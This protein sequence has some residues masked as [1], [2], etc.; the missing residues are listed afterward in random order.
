MLIENQTLLNLYVQ[1]P[2]VK[3]VHIGVGKIDA[4][5]LR[6][7]YK[8]KKILTNNDT[9]FMEA[10]KLNF[11]SI[12]N[13]RFDIKK[14]VCKVM[15]GN[16]I[17]GNI[18]CTELSKGNLDWSEICVLALQTHYIYTI[19][20]IITPANESLIVQNA[21]VLDGHGTKISIIE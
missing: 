5:H 12:I 14:Q 4:K 16:N 20:P 17:L 2:S 18:N 8:W 9:L 6:F 3:S 11:S 13:L 21:F 1:I 19:N 15:E 10:S 7:M